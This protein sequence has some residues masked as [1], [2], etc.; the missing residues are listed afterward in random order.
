MIDYLITGI[1]ILAW[2]I[3]IVLYGVRTDK[4]RRLGLI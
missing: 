3:C 4:L 1:F 2:M